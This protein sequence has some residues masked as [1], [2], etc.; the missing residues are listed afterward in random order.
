MADARVSLP[1]AEMPL[2]STAHIIA[3]SAPLR[4]NRGWREGLQTELLHG[5]KFN[6][7]ETGRGWVFGQAVSLI[8]GSE[9]PGFVGYVPKKAVS[10]D[11]F[12]AS[13]TIVSLNAPVFNKPNIKSH[14]VHALPLNSQVQVQSKEGDFLQVGAGAYIHRRQLRSL[15]EPLSG[16]DFVDVAEMYLEVP[17]V[18]GG[19]GAM[20]VDCSG[21]LQMAL[22]AVGRD[23]PRDADMQEDELG[24]RLAIEET[25][26]LKRGDLIFWPGHIGIMSD[27]DT[28][29]HANAFHM[30]TEKEP[31][32]EAVSRIGTPRR[33]KRIIE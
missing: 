21:L 22:C 3:P 19:T 10:S 5:Q 30:K 14:I 27:A 1:D 7:Y 15:S 26:N 28:M 16:I 20:G 12:E 4:D 17:Y 24:E 11:A 32:A 33:I 8:A 13:H 29:L 31:Y 6:V 23:A 9:R 18:W 2:L 25:E